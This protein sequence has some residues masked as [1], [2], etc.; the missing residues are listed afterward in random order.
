MRVSR[1]FAFFGRM[2][3]LLM[4]IPASV[5]GD[6]SHKGGGRTV[7]TI[8]GTLPGAPPVCSSKRDAADH[9]WCVAP[10]A[11]MPRAYAGRHT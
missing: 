1:A 9:S 11:Q 7:K 5:M 4:A 3:A 10:G 8:P 6:E 2:I